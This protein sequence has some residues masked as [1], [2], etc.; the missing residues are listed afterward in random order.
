MEVR[1]FIDKV[2]SEVVSRNISEPINVNININV[3]SPSLSGNNLSFRFRFRKEMGLAHTHI[4]GSV[5]LQAL[6]GNELNM[7][8]N[9]EKKIRE[10]EIHPLVISIIIIKTQPLV[11]H[12]EDAMGIIP[13]AVPPPPPPTPLTR[14]TGFI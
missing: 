4:E 8:K 13:V 3:D 11:L 9:I 10:G 12:L 2:S 6:D 1:L 7:I 14:S 5:V